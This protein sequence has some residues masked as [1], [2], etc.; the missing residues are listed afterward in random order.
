MCLM[1]GQ[2]Q[3]GKGSFDLTASHSEY[4][5]AQTAQDSLI[6]IVHAWVWQRDSA[7]G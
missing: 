4:L 1:P 7:L 2:T 5:T 6:A 3:H